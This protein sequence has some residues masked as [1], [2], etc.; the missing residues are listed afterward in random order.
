MQIITDYI[1]PD[2]PCHGMAEGPL[3]MP[4]PS[5]RGTRMRWVQRV[6]VIRGDAI[7]KYLWDIGPVED[8]EHDTSPMMSPSFGE[9]TV[10][11]LQEGFERDRHNSRYIQRMREMQDEST[12]VQD[13]I[14]GIE[15]RYRQKT[16]K[17]VSGPKGMTQRGGWSR[18]TAERVLRQRVED[19]KNGY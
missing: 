12:L 15:Q 1:H 13:V 9:N 18:T 10:S 3:T 14:D 8:Y 4:D 7:A 2:E 17:T 5:G 19:R 16:N 6:F 11:Q